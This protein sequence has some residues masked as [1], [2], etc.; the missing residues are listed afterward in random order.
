MAGIKEA[1]SGDAPR[2]LSRLSLPD[3]FAIGEFLGARRFSYYGMASML[4]MGRLI[5]V[6]SRSTAEGERNSINR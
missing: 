2:F 3:F 1:R 4:M 6:I 5:L